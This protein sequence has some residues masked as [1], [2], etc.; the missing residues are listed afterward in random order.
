MIYI[1]IFIFTAFKIKTNMKKI[2]L[3]LAFVMLFINS[4]G[5][6]RADLYNYFNSTK[7]GVG[8]LME[9][10]GEK[11][12]D[13]ATGSPYILKTFSLGNINGVEGSILIKYNAYSDVIELNNG[14][15]KVFILPK[16]QEFNTISLKASSHPYKLFNYR[17]LK[18]E[19][20]NG[21]LI[22][23][24]AENGVALLKREK[25]I[26]IP[27]KQ[28]QNGYGTFSPAKYERVTDDYYLQLKE[29]NIV[30]FPKNKKKLQQLFTTQKD[31]IDTF[32]ES[33]ELS[34]KEEQDMIK[35]T[36]FIATL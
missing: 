20:V 5:Q 11:E 33:N 36:Q 31:A 27:E 23:Q 2:F 21:Y 10:V 18:N 25:I 13:N 28:P 35:I 14:D 22:E 3:V 1:L 6:A 12:T 24:V 29:K 30:P 4:F 26:L 9:K 7:A 8:S 19:E 15:D 32:F 34:F 17:D 16:D